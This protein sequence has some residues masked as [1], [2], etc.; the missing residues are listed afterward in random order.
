MEKRVLWLCVGVA[1][2][3]LVAGILIGHFAIGEQA[4]GMAPGG[5]GRTLPQRDI[6]EQGEIGKI[7]GKNEQSNIE[8]KKCTLFIIFPFCRQFN[9]EQEMIADVIRDVDTKKLR[10]YLKY[11]ADQVR[12]GQEKK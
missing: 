6:G 10:S 7:C 11:L 9:T 2:V 1:A 3:A 5:A 12:R 4:T 8:A